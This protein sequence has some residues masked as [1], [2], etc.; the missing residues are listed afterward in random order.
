M[1]HRTMQLVHGILFLFLF[2]GLV[3]PA[4]AHV[5]V[6]PAEVGV[7]AFQIFTIAVPVEKDV[8][9][10]AVRL[11]IPEGLQHVTPNVKPGWQIDVVTEGEGE[12]AKVTEINWTGGTI[13]PGQRDEFLFSAQVP[14]EE[15]AIVWKAYQTYEDGTTIAWDQN[16]E[17]DGSH[18]ED[19]HDAGPYSETNVINDLQ[20]ATEGT[21]M[22]NAG[23]NNVPMYIS[24]AALLLG[25][26]A[27]LL[28]LNRKK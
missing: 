7:A 21:T 3:S 24:L 11:V 12:T 15:T 8:A 18:S 10:T 1:K 5:T 23:V 14:A 27:L 25:G 26:T 9:T 17:E 19:N 16:P 20:E 13:P 6:K 4:F 22:Q 28:Q 2:L